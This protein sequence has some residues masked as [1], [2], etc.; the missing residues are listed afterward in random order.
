M[1]SKNRELWIIFA[2]ISALFIAFLAVPVIRIFVK[3]FWNGSS[4]T[5]EYYISVVTGKNFTSALANSFKVSAA[6][7]IAA[8]IIAFVIAYALYYTRLPKVIKNILHAITL[9]PMFLPTIT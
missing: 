3:S 8:V 7:A 5:G 9:L 2:V 1:K 4:V 6:A